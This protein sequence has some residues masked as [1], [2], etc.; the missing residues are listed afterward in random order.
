MEES[1][2][3]SLPSSCNE[4]SQPYEP[5]PPNTP[6]PP[7]RTRLARNPYRRNPYQRKPY[8]RNSYQRRN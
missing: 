2:G 3:E 7:Y 4:V 5:K 8:Q 6:E 1:S